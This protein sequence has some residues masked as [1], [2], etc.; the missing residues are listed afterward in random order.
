MGNQKGVRLDYR[1]EISDGVYERAKAE[2]QFSDRLYELMI[3]YQERL[4]S[5]GNKA[6]S[7]PLR[8]SE[9]VGDLN[10]PLSRLY[11]QIW[12]IALGLNKKDA[13]TKQK[14]M[15]VIA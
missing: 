11:N 15:E 9:R 1:Q 6:W 3:K 14:E 2:C 7:K 4:H 10:L 12:T 13:P 8:E 5:T